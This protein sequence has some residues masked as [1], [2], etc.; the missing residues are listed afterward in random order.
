MEIAWF[1]DTWLPNRDGVVTSLLA[2]KKVLEE[3]G[4]VVYIFAPGERDEEEGNIFLYRARTFKPYPQYRFPSLL[5]V[6]SPRTKRIIRKIKPHIIHSHTPGIMGIHAILASRAINAPLFFTFHTFI[7]DSVYL[8]F[9]NEKMQNITKNFIYR[10][11]RWYCGKCKCVMAPS[12]YAAKRLSDICGKEVKIMPTGI[13]IERFEKADGKKL[14]E[15]W[16]GKK[17]I[18]HVGRIVREKNIELLIEAAPHVLRKIDA[19]FVITG[20]GPH[21]NNLQEMVKKKGLEKHFTFTGFVSDEKL[22]SFYKAA[23]VLAFPSVYETQGIVAL[24]AMAA[25][26]PVV[27]ARAKA[28]PDFIKDGE[29]GFLSNP[30]D[31][32]EFAEK[33]IKAIENREVAKRARSY[34]EQYSIEKMAD[35]L[36]GIY[37]GEMQIKD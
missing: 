29:N 32:E 3:R 2:F 6:F 7:D 4:H 33:I 36:L 22:A 18:L 20:E 27:A 1:T 25:G 30:Y 17:I 15:K 34:V 12:N 37:E 11:L 26:V 19:I 23:D 9:K 8:L 13:E 14:R 16:R 24:E 10:W 5:S 31:A 35:K 28:L 21:K